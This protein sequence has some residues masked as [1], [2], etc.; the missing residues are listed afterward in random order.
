MELFKVILQDNREVFRRSVTVIRDQGFFLCGQMLDVLHHLLRRIVSGKSLPEENDWD[1]LLG[2][3][4]IDAQL[5]SIS[6]FMEET[7]FRT[8]A[9]RAAKG[10][11]DVEKEK[12]K[13]LKTNVVGSAV[14]G[15]CLIF[16]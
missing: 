8:K 4:F 7:E 13:K 1:A 5:L 9:M 12:S 2:F 3:E 11:I 10:R 6:Q 16:L 14:M 15:I